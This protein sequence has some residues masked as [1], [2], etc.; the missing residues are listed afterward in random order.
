M[1]GTVLMLVRADRECDFH[2]HLSAMCECL[3]YMFTIDKQNY[4]RWLSVYV[5][6]MN[7]LHSTAPVV[8]NEIF[9]GKAFS[10]RR[11]TQP[12]NGVALDMCL[13]QSL[14]RHSKC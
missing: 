8:Y 12:F 4:A 5:A 10:V 1:C 3:P 14:N 13:E 11:S 9:N 6:D 2:L 7:V